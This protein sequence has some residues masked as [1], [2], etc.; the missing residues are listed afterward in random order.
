MTE[1]YLN[2]LEKLKTAKNI[3]ITCHTNPDGD[4]IGSSLGLYQFLKKVGI[5]A[6]IIVPNDFPAFLKWLPGSSDILLFE[7][8]K[9]KASELLNQA[10]LIF[11]LDFNEP[12][13]VGKME[14]LL[15][16]AKGYKILIDHHIG[17]PNWQNLSFAVVGASSTCELV[18]DFISNLGFTDFLNEAI[19]YAL[20]TG[21]LTDTGNFQYS[22]TSSKVHII[23]ANLIESGVKPALVNDHVNNSFDINRLSFFGFCISKKM[24]LLPKIKLAYIEAS[25]KSMQDYN[26]KTGGTEGL[27]NEPM[28]ISEVQI[29]V[30]FK[31]DVDKIKISF[32]SKGSIDVSHFAK[33]YFKGGGHFNAAGGVSYLSMEETIEKFLSHIS[34]FNNH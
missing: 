15:S 30:L 20:Y 14:T 9:L 19:A 34:Y 29:S 26:I 2:V 32:R 6:Q 4:A 11:C 23:A 18:Y 7:T 5:D 28:K 21:L 3:V 25:R 12:Y 1:K 22:A 10:E 17:N 27:V 24:T 13:R 33:K 31:E 16:E 8:H